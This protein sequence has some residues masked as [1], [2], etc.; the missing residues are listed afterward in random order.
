[1]ETDKETSYDIAYYDGRIII[2]VQIMRLKKDSTKRVSL[3]LKCILWLLLL[4]AVFQ[5]ARF[6][7]NYGRAV[8]MDEAMTEIGVNDDVELLILDGADIKRVAEELEDAAVIDDETLFYL[9]AVL[10]GKS[11][12]IV[13][14]TYIFNSSMKPSKI[15]DMLQSGPTE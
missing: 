5:A 10:S 3:L 2:G 8:F 6:S 12:D 1:M 7:Y 13:G 4:F 11:K 15:L 14:G 9:Q